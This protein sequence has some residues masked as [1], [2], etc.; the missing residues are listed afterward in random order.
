MSDIV[1][2]RS[3]GLYCPAGDFYIDQWQPVARAVVTRADSD[4]AQ[5]G[6][7]E[8]LAHR[9]SDATIRRRLGQ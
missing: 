5:S 2:Q 8:Y 1:N 6:N 7:V 4:H 9:D 3:E